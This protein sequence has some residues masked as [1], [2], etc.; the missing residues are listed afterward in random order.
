MDAMLQ[1]GDFK[2]A[3]LICVLV[4]SITM[5]VPAHATDLPVQGG[6]GGASFRTDCSGDFVT[7]VY[8]KSGN[9]IDAI[10]LKCS[11]FLP[12]QGAFKQPPWN[13]SYH[14][15]QGGTLQEASLCPANAVVTGMTIGFVYDKDYK[16]K[17]KFVRYVKLVCTPL[18]DGSLTHV[19]VHSGVGCETGPLA[20]QNCPPGEA[21]TGLQGRAG[22]YV[23]ALGLICGPKPSKK[24]SKRL[25]RPKKTAP[26]PGS[27]P[28]SPDKTCKVKKPSDVY[29]QPD[30]RGKKYDGFLR[31]GAPG[32]VLVEP[33][34]DNWCHVKGDSVPGGQGWVYSSPD[35][36]DAL[37]CP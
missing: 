18:G 5:S 19:C 6:P 14:G 10:G 11:E 33:C 25:G 1:N 16:D 29:D 20:E 31:A 9:W 12:A 24:V 35:D 28:P 27:P 36:Y 21:A 7:G 15:G 32:V 4:A 37:D 22:T 13:K 30:G 2:A 26:A 17:R 8:V 3:A 34:R 23:D